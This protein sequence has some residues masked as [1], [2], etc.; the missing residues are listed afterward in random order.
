MLLYSDEVHIWPEKPSPATGNIT[1][2]LVPLSLLAQDFIDMAGSET[3]IFLLSRRGGVAVLSL[4]DFNMTFYKA[5][6]DGYFSKI[7]VYGE[8]I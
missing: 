7:S 4:A 8:T 3:N 6:V 2:H 5:K 1:K